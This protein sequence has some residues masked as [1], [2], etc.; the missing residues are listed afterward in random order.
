M[1]E[2][3]A[4]YLHGTFQTGIKKVDWQLDKIMKAMWQ[5]LH[6]SPTRRDVNSKVLE[7]EEFPLK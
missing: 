4:W 1:W 5:L 6:D 7:S 2:A 3:V